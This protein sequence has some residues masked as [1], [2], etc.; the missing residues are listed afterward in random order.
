M[1]PQLSNPGTIENLKYLTTRAFPN[2]NTIKHDTFNNGVTADQSYFKAPTIKHEIF[3]NRVIDERSLTASN[4]VFKN[5]VATWCPSCQCSCYQTWSILL[6]NHR[7]LPNTS[8]HIKFFLSYNRGT[9]KLYQAWSIFYFT[10][11]ALPNTIKVFLPYIG[12][13]WA[14]PNNIKHSIFT[15]QQGCSQALSNQKY[16]YYT[17]GVL[18]DLKYFYNRALPSTIKPK[19]FLQQGTP[20]HYQTRSIFTL[21]QGCCQT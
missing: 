13:R 21:Q 7:A 18:P 20:K 5:G 19:V 14:L 12:H 4:K 8:K 16:F 15:F 6:C 10:T 2:G 11:G 9:S 3:N 1:E 17:T